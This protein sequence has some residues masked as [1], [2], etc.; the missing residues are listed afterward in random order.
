[1]TSYAAS[2]ANEATLRASEQNLRLGPLAG[3]SG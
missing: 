1:L 3:G 2:S